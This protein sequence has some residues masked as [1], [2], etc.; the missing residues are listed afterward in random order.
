MPVGGFSLLGVAL[1]LR[2]TVG[3][4]MH[5]S[6]DTARHGCLSSLKHKVAKL[7]VEF[8]FVVKRVISTSVLEKPGQHDLS[9]DGS[10]AN[11]AIPMLAR[12]GMVAE[13]PLS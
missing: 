8:F 12:Q 9:S 7:L 10:C 11:L 1:R 2:L 3:S 5:C 13:S 6:G 4:N